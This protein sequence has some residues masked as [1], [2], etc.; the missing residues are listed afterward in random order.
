[1]S[2]NEEYAYIYKCSFFESKRHRISHTDMY[3]Q[4][5]EHTR[6]VHNDPL[7]KVFVIKV[8]TDS[9]YYESAVDN[10]NNPNNQ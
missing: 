4:K 9:V 6:W 5:E 1:M 7:G 10:S 2:Q 8:R 3:F